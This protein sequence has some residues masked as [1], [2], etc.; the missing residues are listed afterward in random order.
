VDAPSSPSLESTG[1]VVV[2]HGSRRD[3][4][5]R[6]L[7]VMVDMVRRVV[8]YPI[9]EPAHMELAEPSIAT[10]FDACV[11]QGATTVVISPYFLLPGKHWTED[12]PALSEEAAA[13][14]PG[15][16]FLVTA[17]LGLH[18]MM[19]EVVG[20]RVAHCLAHV[21]GRAGECEACE[22]T[23]ACAMRTAPSRAA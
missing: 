16:R 7:E 17:P 1:L 10:A 13:R 11:A 2:D 6:M 23:G 19:A 3:E 4:S 12:I 21:D 8:P 22:G 18:P 5:N 15:V 9:V 20:S 14:H